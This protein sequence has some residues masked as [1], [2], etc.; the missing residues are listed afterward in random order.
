M[1]IEGS[2]D[3]MKDYLSEY[4]TLVDLHKE[5]GFNIHQ[6]TKDGFSLW[7]KLPFSQKTYQ[8]N[9]E[10][11]KTS[12]LAKIA[13]VDT[14]FES[15]FGYFPINLQEGQS[16]GI[17]YF[18]FLNDA[19]GETF[20]WLCSILAYHISP[21]PEAIKGE[22][23][24]DNFNYYADIEWKI[25]QFRALSK[26]YNA[27]LPRTYKEFLS[28][29]ERAVRAGVSYYTASANDENQKNLDESKKALIKAGITDFSEENLRKHIE[30]KDKAVMAQISLWQ[31]KDGI[32]KCLKETSITLDSEL[33]EIHQ[34]Q[35]LLSSGDFEQKKLEE[36]YSRVI[37]LMKKPR[38]RQKVIVSK[39]P[40]QV[41]PT[42]G[43]L[44]GFSMTPKL[45]K[46]TTPQEVRACEE[47]ENALK[48][49]EKRTA[50]L[51]AK[52]SELDKAIADIKAVI[53][54]MPYGDF[55]V[56]TPERK[57][58]NEKLEKTQKERD[59]LQ[60]ELDSI[61]EE[62]KAKARDIIIDRRNGVNS[63]YV[64]VTGATIYFNDEKSAV[65]IPYETQHSQTIIRLPIY[66]AIGESK[67]DASLTSVILQEIFSL[68]VKQKSYKVTI[69]NDVIWA[70]M[71]CD[72]QSSKDE[73]KK[74]KRLY[75]RNYLDYLSHT[76]IINAQ[77][78]P[79]R[80]Q[81][82]Y[83]YTTPKEEQS[84]KGNIITYIDSKSDPAK[85]VL[86]YLNEG[87][88][89]DYIAHSPK[90]MIEGR[91][92]CNTPSQERDLQIFRNRETQGDNSASVYTVKGI[93]QH[94]PNYIDPDKHTGSNYTRD[95]VDP[96]KNDFEELFKKGA[97]AQADQIST[98]EWLIQTAQGKA[99][100]E[101]KG[102]RKP[103]A[104][105]NNPK[106]K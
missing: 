40:I 2:F 11:F 61:P 106:K 81:V 35:V 10:T 55:L 67:G 79:T 52:I 37:S 70:R 20:N 27:Q 24:K 98:E 60:K 49:R 83:G 50:S 84:I 104:I 97:L 38:G 65:D 25:E 88:F 68:A 57:E 17:K 31:F 1:E 13:I 30:A 87:L 47:Y 9:L 100:I 94:N 5:K 82:K 53:S 74:K 103:S 75:I 7:I 59:R 46:A 95:V 63:Y 91:D 33:K 42:N 23:T 80:A 43:S 32:I 66:V 64:N 73:R 89:N 99:E 96:P 12:K 58:Q 19:Q 39:N 22:I 92:L 76:D 69:S 28:A 34:E 101:A 44:S 14:D 15:V 86:V 45:K 72:R 8:T 102:K 54:T 105:I 85:G 78:T 36:I 4:Q 90:T 48:E 16:A 29:I 71:G 26:K 93:A 3:T 21:K 18:I 62:I 6:I 56:Q 41:L 51:T 77:S